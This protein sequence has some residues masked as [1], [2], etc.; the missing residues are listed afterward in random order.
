M[1]GGFIVPLLQ[2]GKFKQREIEWVKEGRPEL[3]F[4]SAKCQPQAHAPLFEN[5]RVLMLC[6]EKEKK[7][8]LQKL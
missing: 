8:S 6:V 7:K 1:S 2:T 4:P 5:H 3:K